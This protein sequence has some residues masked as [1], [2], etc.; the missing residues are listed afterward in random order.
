MATS[1]L[2]QRRAR[3]FSETDRLMAR[4]QEFS[5]DSQAVS[6]PLLIGGASRSR[7]MTVLSEP[8]IH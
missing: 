4:L 8:I 6:A 5:A 1:I 3:A 2:P 7:P